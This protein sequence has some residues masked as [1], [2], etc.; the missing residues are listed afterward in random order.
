MRVK[1]PHGNSYFGKTSLI[2]TIQGYT[3]QSLLMSMGV[4]TDMA[5]V[6]FH[7]GYMYPPL[8]QQGG[9]WGLGGDFDQ[10]TEIKP[11]IWP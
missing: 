3:F 1:K 10:S 11:P 5:D 2:R 4:V 8:P 9:G 6:T 7:D